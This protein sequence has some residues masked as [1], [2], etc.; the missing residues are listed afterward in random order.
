M[1]KQE[2]QRQH[3]RILNNYRTPYSKSDDCTE[4]S[5]KYC[6]S[7][8]TELQEQ[9]IS[10]V[11]TLEER[12]AAYREVKD[13]VEGL[14]AKNEIYVK[15]H[16]QLLDRLDSWISYPENRPEIYGKYFIN[17]KDGKV[18]WETWNGSGWAYNEKVITHWMEI[19]KPI[20]QDKE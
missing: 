2:L 17:R 3:L 1:T 13:E 11:S 7:Q 12:D 14:K 5:I 19:P 18:H 20:I 9:I 8:T 16:D 6:D 4:L 15:W 10:L